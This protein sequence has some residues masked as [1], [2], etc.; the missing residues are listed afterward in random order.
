MAEAAGRLADAHAIRGADAVHLSAFE[1]LVAAC[2]D[3][4]IRFSTA[5]A[6]LA[7]AAREIG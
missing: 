7:R 3:D 5:D 2:T 4:D 6:K 1:A